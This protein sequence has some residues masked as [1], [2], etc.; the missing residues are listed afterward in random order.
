MVQD[1]SQEETGGFDAR[2]LR[3]E[4]TRK[5]YD[6]SLQMFQSIYMDRYIKRYRDYEPIYQKQKCYKDY[7]A[8]LSYE[9]TPFLSIGTHCAFT[10]VNKLRSRLNVVRW[11]PEGRRLL[12]GG[13]TGEMTLWNGFSY[14]FETLMQAHDEAIMDIEWS[15]DGDWLVT[16]D[17]AGF[18][19]YWEKTLNNV[20]IFAAH[21]EDVNS[22]SFS[23][24][25][26]KFATCSA[27]KTIKVWDFMTAEEELCLSGHCW[28]VKIVDWN[29]RMAVIASGGKDNMIKLWD[30]RTR[31][32]I[33]TLHSHKN[34][35]MSLRWNRK[36]PDLLLSGGKDNVVSLFDLR[37]GKELRVFKG[38]RKDVQAVTWHPI[39]GNMFTSGSLDGAIMH[40]TT[41]SVCAIKELNQAHDN[42]I[43]SLDWHPFGHCLSSGAVDGITRFW[44]KN[45]P[46][47]EALQEET[48]EK[49]IEEFPGLDLR[50]ETAQEETVREETAQEERKILDP[51]KRIRKNVY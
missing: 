12:A 24:N 40:W 27:D 14:H 15:S 1:V 7:A 49:P 23:G 38:H 4:I 10:A 51:R 22:I 33:K 42:G 19:K 21:K 48:A 45:S 5:H 3:K 35:V 46:A 20:K 29:S 34:T 37:A 26:Q 18:V 39:H 9:G 13:R 11:S 6:Y 50:E 47:R 17:I 16:C 25:N 44:I 36:F 31:E 32:C 28:D 2:T 8:P 43:S 41:N 30:P